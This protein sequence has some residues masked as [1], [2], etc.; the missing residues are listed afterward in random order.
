MK[1]G[2][3]V[4]VVFIILSILLIVASIYMYREQDKVSPEF[5]FSAL[6]MV[7]SEETTE[8]DLLQGIKAY[9]GVDGDIS[10]RIVIEKVV[11]NNDAQT[12]VVYYAVS[13]L[14]GNVTKQSR[15][16]PVDD[17]FAEEE[18]EQEIVDYSDIYISVDEVAEEADSAESASS[19]E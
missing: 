8:Y 19:Q 3:F 16:F 1:K 9:D 18:T 7:Y 15:V 13:D 6:D 11:V 10:D 12:A 14:S 4:A 2:N 5:R 17:T